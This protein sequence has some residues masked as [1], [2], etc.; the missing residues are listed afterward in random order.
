VTYINVVSCLQLDKWLNTIKE[1]MQY[2]K[3]NSI[4]EL[5]K[6]P[7]GYELISCK[8]VYKTKRGSKERLESLK[9]N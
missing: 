1:E 3:H 7:K 5:V 6:L 2:M 9:P 8:W 4:W